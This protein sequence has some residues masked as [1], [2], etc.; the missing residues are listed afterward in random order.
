MENFELRKYK[1]G[2]TK[3]LGVSWNKQR[4]K[5]VATI[6]VENKTRYLGAFDEINE[7]AKAYTKAKKNRIN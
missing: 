2:S 1:N 3:Y 4:R 5:Y 7:A 6:K